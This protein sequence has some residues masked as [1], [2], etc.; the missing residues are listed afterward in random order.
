MLPDEPGRNNV[1]SGLISYLN[2]ITTLPEL[3]PPLATLIPLTGWL[4]K[5]LIIDCL[6]TVQ[7]ALKIGLPFASVIVAVS[8]TAIGF[9]HSI[10]LIK[11][12]VLESP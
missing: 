2:D 12:T 1:K 5:Y 8:P 7:V 10:E 3:T 4:K 6:A 11:N 9:C